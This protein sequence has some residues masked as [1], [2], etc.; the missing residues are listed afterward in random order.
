M[1]G[2]GEVLQDLRRRQADDHAQGDEEGQVRRQEVPRAQ[3][4]AGMP[5]E[6]LPRQLPAIT[7]G[8]HSYG[9]H[10]YGLHRHAGR[11]AAP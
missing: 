10:S 11:T 9:L 4:V 8:L 6:Q 1:G 2:L 3:E 7:Y 5:E